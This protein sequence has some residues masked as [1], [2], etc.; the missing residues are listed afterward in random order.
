MRVS[1]DFSFSSDEVREWCQESGDSNPLHLDASVVEESEYFE[2]RVV[3][4]MMLLDK[5]SGLI[6]EWAQ[7][8][9]GTPVISRMGG[10]SFDMPVHIDESVEIEISESEEQDGSYV[11]KFAVGAPAAEPRAQ[12]FVTVY[13]L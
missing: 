12:G 4:G 3:P 10:I 1:K 2:E 11:L 6:T 7:T 13:L 5:V 8:K 9:E